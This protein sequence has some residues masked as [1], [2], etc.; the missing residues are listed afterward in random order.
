MRAY[1]GVL[2]GHR[3]LAPCGASTSAGA[4]RDVRRAHRLQPVMR[5]IATPLSRVPPHSLSA[6]LPLGEALGAITAVAESVFRAVRGTG[7]GY[8]GRP[9]AGGIRKLGASR[10]PESAKA[11]LPVNRYWRVKT[12]LFNSDRCWSMVFWSRGGARRAARYSRGSCSCRAAAGRR[13][14]AAPPR[15]RAA[16][17]PGR[18]APRPTPK[19]SARSRTWAVIRAW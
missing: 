4:G 10:P 12:R 2:P 13:A 11:G 6:C 15:P 8:P 19:R 17:P 16:P 1:P 3:M 7:N 5:T 14:A 18:P 9:V